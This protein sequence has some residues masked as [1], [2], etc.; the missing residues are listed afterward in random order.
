[1]P[2]KSQHESSSKKIIIYG[3]LLDNFSLDKKYKQGINAMQTFIQYGFRK[4][5]L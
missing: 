4:W 3:C 2:R 5:G 1:M